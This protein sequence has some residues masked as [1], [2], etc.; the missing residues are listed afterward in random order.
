MS[1]IEASAAGLVVV[2]TAAAG[3][4]FIYTH[5]RNAMLVEPRNA[6]DLADAVIRVLREPELARSLSTNAE[7]IAN[8]CDWQQVRRALYACYQFV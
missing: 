7:A 4:P 5:G 2:S 3:I 6:T 8:Q 1:L